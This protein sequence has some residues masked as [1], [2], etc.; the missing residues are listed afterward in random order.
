MSLFFTKVGQPSWKNTGW[1]SKRY[2]LEWIL[3]R[4]HHNHTFKGEIMIFLLPFI[5]CND[6]EKQDTGE[7]GFMCSETCSERITYNFSSELES[8]TAVMTI[9]TYDGSEEVTLAFEG[10]T[11]DAVVEPY[12]YVRADSSSIFIEGEWTYP[13]DASAVVIEIDGVVIEPTDEVKGSQTACGY[14]CMDDSYTLNV[15]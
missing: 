12:T 10:I 13:V 9:S 3:H 14:T 1:W 4:V 6:S 2:V 15:D 8:Y 5:A 7:M 11:V